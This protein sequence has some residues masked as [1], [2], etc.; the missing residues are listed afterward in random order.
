[1]RARSPLDHAD[2]NYTCHYKCRS[3]VTL[4][5]AAVMSTDELSEQSWHTATSEELALIGHKRRTAASTDF[6]DAVRG[7]IDFID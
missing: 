4:D 7:L 6:E 5:C 2:C 1:M 3:L